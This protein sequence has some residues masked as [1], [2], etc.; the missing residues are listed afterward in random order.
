MHHRGKRSRCIMEGG[1]VVYIIEGLPWASWSGVM[2]P[3]GR[4]SICIMEGGGVV[5]IIQ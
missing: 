4:R 2:H 1:R 3:R 5:C